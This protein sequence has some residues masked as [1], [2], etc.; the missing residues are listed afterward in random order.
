MRLRLVVGPQPIIPVELEVAVEL[1]WVEVTLALGLFELP[2]EPFL[3][4]SHAETNESR[5][6][7][8]KTR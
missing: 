7:P 3:S 6:T 5:H 1:A 4:S 2:L 8:A